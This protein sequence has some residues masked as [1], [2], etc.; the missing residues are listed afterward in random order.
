MTDLETMTC[1][2]CKS[3]MDE[4][5]FVLLTHDM[6]KAGWLPGTPIAVNASR[7]IFLSA[8]ASNNSVSSSLALGPS[9]MPARGSSRVSIDRFRSLGIHRCCAAPLQRRFA[10]PE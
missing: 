2:K 10:M 1:A 9:K 4:G 6:R 8:S 5:A 7:M 3:K